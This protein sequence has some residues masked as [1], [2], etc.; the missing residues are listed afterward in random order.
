MVLYDTPWTRR[1][2]VAGVEDTAPPL[3]TE[4]Q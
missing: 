2:L 1:P 4:P 3:P